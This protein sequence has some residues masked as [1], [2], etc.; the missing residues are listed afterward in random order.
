MKEM[1]SRQV[2]GD[3]ASI[4]GD[5]PAWVIGGFGLPDG[6]RWEF[7]EPDAIAVV[8][9]GRLRLTVRELTR[10]HDR[11]QILD[12]AKHMFYSTERF[13]VAED[14]GISFGL[15]IRSRCT[16]TAPGDL[17]DGYVSF[18]LLDLSQG[19]ALDWFVGHDLIAPVNARLPFPGVNAGDARPLKYYAVFEEL[20]HTP[21]TERRV[22]IAYDRARNEAVWSLDGSE[23]RRALIPVPLEGF[24][25]ALGIM[26]EKDIGPSGSVSCHGQGVTGEWSPFEIEGWG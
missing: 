7:R 25:A 5:R 23:V 21:G 26:T 2:Y 13:P 19:V 1:V 15:S 4:V 20:E 10:R 3:F 24:V 6:S 12:N 22:K 9:N 14:G 17:Y 8:Q 11:I 16:G 18:N